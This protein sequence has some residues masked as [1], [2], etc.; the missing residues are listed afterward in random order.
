MVRTGQA[1]D[2]VEI[3]YDNPRRPRLGLEALSY[4]EL[5]GRLQPGRF[6][7]VSRLD[8][9]QLILVTGG[10]GMAMVDFVAH[11]CQ[12]GTVLWVR[13]GQL[14]RLPT[15]RDGAPARLDATVLLFTPAFVPAFGA[16]GAAGQVDALLQAPAAALWSLAPAEYAPLAGAA[17]EVLAEYERLPSGGELTVELLRLLLAGLLV[18][19]ARCTPAA[20]PGLPAD[21]VLRRFQAE[22]E[23]SFAETRRA[24]DYADRL[25]WAPRTLNRACQAATGRSAKQLI[26]ERV[27]LEASRLLV[28]TDLPVAAVGRRVGFGEPTNFGKF[29]L[30]ETGRTPGEFR[31]TERMSWIGEP[32]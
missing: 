29:F 3:G 1:A 8:F 7:P 26:E 31:S 15:A 19:L 16:S 27:V 4:A 13:P 32:K 10:E 21:S 30:R 22:L 14:Q 5:S 25:G 28:H 23:R 18:R 2:V 11:P 9:H 6:R 12:A 24:Q 17:A 20:G